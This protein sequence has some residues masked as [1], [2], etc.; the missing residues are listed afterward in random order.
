MTS[1]LI[2]PAGH[3]YTE[4]ANLLKS[5]GDEPLVFVP[6]P[7]NAGDAVIN[8]GMYELFNDLGVKWEYGSYEKNYPGRAIVFS[9]GG[10]LVDIYPH[11]DNFF[12]RN[13]PVCKSLILLPHTV[14]GYADLVEEMDSRCHLFAREKQSYAFLSAHNKRGAH[15]Y[16]SHDLAFY[17]SD[18][19]IA[20]KPWD[21][22]FLSHPTIRK[23]WLKMAAKIWFS[24]LKSPKLNVIRADVEATSTP[25]PKENFDLSMMFASGHLRST[26]MFMNPGVCA[27]TTKAMRMLLRS[28]SRVSTNR[29]HIAILSAISGKPVTM[30]DN[31]YGKNKN[32]YDHSI[33]GFYDQVTFS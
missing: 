6:N 5:F 2:G 31:A 14:Q 25:V 1:A 7:G 9:G 32:I 13:H 23:S 11:A 19:R 22:G 3:D 17:L 15:V 20:A 8:L 28:F 26:R 33:R 21:W 24:H 4:L 16:Q 29:L 12:R 27:S 10:A 18:R 30:M